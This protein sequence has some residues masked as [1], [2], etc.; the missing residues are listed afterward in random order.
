[1]VGGEDGLPH[2]PQRHHANKF[3][4]EEER[5]AD[6]GADMLVQPPNHQPALIP[7]HVV[8]ESGPAMEGNPAGQALANPQL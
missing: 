8:H 6:G 1:M 3:F 7:A 4:P 5:D 2:T